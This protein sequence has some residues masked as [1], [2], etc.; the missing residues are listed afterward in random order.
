MFPSIDEALDSPRF[1]PFKH[2][3]CEK[4]ER[5]DFIGYWIHTGPLGAPKKPSECDIVLLHIHGGAYVAGHPLATLGQLLRIAET[6]AEEGI[7]ISTF[8]LNYSLGP[9]AVFPTQQNEAVAAYRYLTDKDQLAID[10]PKIIVYGE[11]AGGHLAVALLDRLY[12][13]KLPCPG[14][15]MLNAPWVNMLD[16]GNSFVRNK[17]LDLLHK[18]SLDKC[19]KDVSRGQTDQHKINQMLDL[20]AIVT[21]DCNFLPPVTWVTVGAHDLFHDD[22]ALFV[23]NARNA[24]ANVI[25]EVV[26]GMPHVWQHIDMFRRKEY[27]KLQPGEPVAGDLMKGTNNI[28]KGLLQVYRQQKL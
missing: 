18:P 27:F 5:P 2:N 10:P 3:L 22:V 26:P 21:K 8:S 23:E 1:G 13:E 7:T 28:S 12:A 20:T 6:C 15:A 16:T 11:S 4:V 19:A 25:S 24:G 17:H 9:E 14:G